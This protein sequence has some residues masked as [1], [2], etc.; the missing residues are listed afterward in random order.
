MLELAAIFKIL[1]IGVVSHFSANVL[2]NMGH[3][4]KVMYIKIAGYVACAYVSLDAWWDCLRMVARTF[5]V[6]V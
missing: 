4:G 1:G 6:H 2:E 5:G 3:G